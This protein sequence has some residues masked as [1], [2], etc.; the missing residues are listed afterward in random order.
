MN[1]RILGSLIG[2]VIVVIVLALITT[3]RPTTVEVKEIKAEF[4]PTVEVATQEVVKASEKVERHKPYYR[5]DIPLS[6]QEQT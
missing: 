4:K 3:P 6:E 5:E 2:L 1:K